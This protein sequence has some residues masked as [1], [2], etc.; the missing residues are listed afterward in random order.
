ME[1]ESETLPAGIVRR[2]IRIERY[3]QLLFIAEI[4]AVAV[5]ALII[6]WIAKFAG[7]FG[8]FLTFN[9]HPFFMILGFVIIT[10][11]SV[12]IYRSLLG[13][14]RTTV[15]LIHFILNCLTLACIVL[16]LYSVFN[17]SGSAWLY[18]LHSWCGVATV[19]VFALQFIVGV[20]SFL[21]PFIGE[22]KRKNLLPYHA[23]FGTAIFVAASATCLM[24]ATEFALLELTG[25]EAYNKKP[26]G[27]FVINFL[28]LSI[29]LFAALVV[30][31]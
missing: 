24:G 22:E 14:R 27:A 10:G 15:K 17:G 21:V 5:I 3:Y 31:M 28:G 19:L 29:F 30:Y 16:A 12:L 23:F 9:Y 7:G 13:P 18:S 26:P 6:T 1:M 8:S 20:F 4:I 2:I 11:N 25:E